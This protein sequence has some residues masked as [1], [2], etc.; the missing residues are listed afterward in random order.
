MRNYILILCFFIITGCV[1]SM[2]NPS[3]S[4]S[5]EIAGKWEGGF[6]MPGGRLKKVSFEFNKSKDIVT[7]D[8]LFSGNRTPIIDGSIS[9]NKITFQTRFDNEGDTVT[10]YYEGTVKKDRIRM[11]CLAEAGNGKMTMRGEFRLIN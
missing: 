9:G 4:S 3:A 6:G 7:G 2:Q 1:N 5:V 8:V 11:K 10:S